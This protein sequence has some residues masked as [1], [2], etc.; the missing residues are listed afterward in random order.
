VVTNPQG[1]QF[2]V[3]DVR[4]VAKWFIA[5]GLDVDPDELAA[6]LLADAGVR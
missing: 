4:N 1:A 5:R 2:L 3:R 6:T